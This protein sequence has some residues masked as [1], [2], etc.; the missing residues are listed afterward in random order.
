MLFQ[1]TNAKRSRGEYLQQN[2]NQNKKI[3]WYKVPAKEPSEKNK[4]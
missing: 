3:I 1:N 4:Y 2:E